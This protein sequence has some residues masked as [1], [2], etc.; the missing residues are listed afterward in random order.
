VKVTERD[1]RDKNA[2][3]PADEAWVAISDLCDGDLEIDG[4]RAGL[5]QLARIFLRCADDSTRGREYR[6][7][8]GAT[9]DFRAL[10]GGDS[11]LAVEQVNLLERPKP[12]IVQPTGFRPWLRDKL[13]LWGFGLIVFLIASVFLAGLGVVTGIIKVK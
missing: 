6:S 12:P 9:A 5:R 3:P 4:N 2:V 8:G 11:A 1:A 10:L 13:F 7:T